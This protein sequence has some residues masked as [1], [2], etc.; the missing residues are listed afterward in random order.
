LKSSRAIDAEIVYE[1]VSKTGRYLEKQSPKILEEVF[2]EINS[3]LKQDLSAE[4]KAKLKSII[5]LRAANWSVPIEREP[6]P[7][8]PIS[9]T[10]QPISVARPV[11]TPF[12]YEEYEDDV[13]GGDEVEDYD[14][15]EDDPE[16]YEQYEK[17]RRTNQ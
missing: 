7:V 16:Y 6:P 14:E 13:E 11:Y 8:Q 5:D 1:L 15:Y 3:T 9:I 12:Y 17:T 2:Q 4:I 10:Q